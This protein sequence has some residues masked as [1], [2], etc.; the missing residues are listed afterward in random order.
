MSTMELYEI[1]R[2]LCIAK[3]R[4]QRVIWWSLI[5]IL[6]FT[7]GVWESFGNQAKHCPRPKV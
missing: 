6:F 7:S 2:T 4:T 1:A 3:W 5:Q